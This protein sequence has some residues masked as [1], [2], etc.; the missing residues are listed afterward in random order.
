[1]GLGSTAKKLQ[2]VAD[3]AEDL[4]GR[5]NEL[6]E[7]V[8]QMEETVDETNNR[9]TDLERTHAEQRALLEAMAEQQN[10]QV[11]EVI[12]DVEAET[13]DEEATGPVEEG[14]TRSTSAVSGTADENA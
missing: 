2:R 14:D 4:V 5:L 6:R 9:L 8:I 13:S 3:M 10:I 11:E 7:R 12:A 1:M